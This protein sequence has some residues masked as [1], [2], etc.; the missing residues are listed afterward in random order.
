MRPSKAFL[1]ISLL[2]ALA[3]SCG[4]VLGPDSLDTGEGK[5]LVSVRLAGEQVSGSTAR[6]ILSQKPASLR[7]VLWG[8]LV[9]GSERKLT[10]F[11]SPAGATLTLEPGTWA[12][13]LEGRSVD[14]AVLLD[15]SLD[16]RVIGSAVATVLTFE[17]RP[18]STGYGDILADLCLPSVNAVETVKVFLD[19]S[20]VTPAPPIVEGRIA[21]SM[22]AVVSGDQILTFRFYDHGIHL[23]AS[24][25]ELLR[26]R[27]NL[28]CSWIQQL[29][30]EAFNAPPSA[31][32]TPRATRMPT[33]DPNGLISLAWTRD[34]ETETGQVITYTDGSSASGTISVDAGRSA[35][36]WSGALRGKSYSFTVR[37]FNDFG[38]SMDTVP[39]GPVAVPLRQTLLYSCDRTVVLSGDLPPAIVHEPE[40]IITVAGNSGGLRRDGYAF[41]G[42][43]TASDG[44]GVA[45]QAGGR[46]TVESDL[47]LYSRWLA[48]AN[49]SQGKTVV[50]R[51]IESDSFPGSAAVDGQSG[52]RWASS[53]DFSLPQWLY[54]DLA[55][56]YT[57]ARVLLSFEAGSS[58]YYLQYSDADDLVSNPAWTDI[59]TSRSTGNG[60]SATIDTGLPARARYVRVLAKNTLG[61][62][63]VSLYEFQIYGAMP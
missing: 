22:K 55:G 57:I 56:H 60:Q 30:A 48:S 50:V 32:I 45:Y 2:S 49:I 47:V 5:A 10:A 62:V 24:V 7:Y 28:T 34:S 19:G 36:L 16:P 53:S 33:D 35:C 6:T 21:F 26:V 63:G 18:I 15:A 12:F 42:W 41:A 27:Q 44:S 51:S 29:S 58:N 54:V 23:L 9:G 8:S 38:S 17:L 43:N 14:E 3:I 52:T 37:A 11:D 61:T 4:G 46:Y 1:L 13:R 40:S 31:P 39:T 25:S 20:L 59:G